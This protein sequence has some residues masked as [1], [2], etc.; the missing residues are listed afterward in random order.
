MIYVFATTAAE[1]ASLRQ[2]LKSFA[3]GYYG[4]L[5]SV[6]VDPLD[7]PDLPAQL[8][9][10]PGLYPAGAVHQLSKDRVYPYPRGRGLSSNDL[11]MWGIDVWQGRIRPWTPP[12]VT[13][14]YDDLGPTK[15][16]KRSVSVRSIPGMKSPIKIAGYNHDDL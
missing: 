13:T 7:F 1:R 9:L 16:A 10:T 5:T 14:S 2:T 6:T 11:Q 3:K 15:M 12:G 8:G 4:S